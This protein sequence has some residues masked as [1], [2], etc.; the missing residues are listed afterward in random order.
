MPLNQAV[1]GYYASHWFKARPEQ[2]QEAFDTVADLVLSQRIRVAVAERLP[3]EGAAEAH[4]IME[5]RRSTGKFVLKP[6]LGSARPDH[7]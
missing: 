6:W 7:A 3:L 4:R 5:T 2:A 1:I